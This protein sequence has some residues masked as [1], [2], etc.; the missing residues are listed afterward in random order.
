MQSKFSGK[1]DL[2][3][4]NK[5]LLYSEYSNQDRTFIEAPCQIA[6]SLPLQPTPHVPSLPEV[7]S[8][9]LVFIRSQRS[10]YSDPITWTYP[11]SIIEDN[12]TPLNVPH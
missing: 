3:K 9:T 4:V 11:T 10:T 12:M 1:Q 7:T 8:I 2:H 6:F 5:H